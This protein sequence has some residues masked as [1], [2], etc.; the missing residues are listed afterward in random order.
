MGEV[1][2][3]GIGEEFHI[4]H[5]PVVVEHVHLAEGGV[6]EGWVEEGVLDWD[7]VLLNIAEGVFLQP[8]WVFVKNN[9]KHIPIIQRFVR[10]HLLPNQDKNW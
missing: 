3:Y 7:S 5:L 10:L 6:E 8:L 4:G 2:Y 1:V 9:L